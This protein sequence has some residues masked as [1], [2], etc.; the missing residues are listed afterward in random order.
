MKGYKGESNANMM[1]L[2]IFWR[3]TLQM[4]APNQLSNVDVLDGQE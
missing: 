2:F 4:I 1:N 3:L